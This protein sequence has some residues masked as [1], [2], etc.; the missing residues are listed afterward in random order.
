MTEEG[1][2]TLMEKQMEYVSDG[3]HN[4][5]RINYGEE[6]KNSYSYRMIMEN[7]IKGLLPC[8]VRMVNGDT[9]LYYEVQSKQT[10]HCRFE[11][12][13]IDYEALRNIFLHLCA[14]GNELEK[15]LL[16]LE[17]IVFSENYIFQ[18]VETGETYFM[19]LPNKEKKEDSYAEFME[20]IVKRIDHRD[21]KAVQISY[22]L[23]D[24]SRTEHISV[25]EIWELFE[26]ECTKKEIEKNIN[27]TPVVN[28]ETWENYGKK[29]E[30]EETVKNQMQKLE[31]NYME[32]ENSEEEK[33]AEKSK[34]KDIL[35]SCFCVITFTILLCI[36]ISVRLTY[37][38]ETLLLAGMAVD[39]GIFFIHMCY[40]YWNRRKKNKEKPNQNTSRKKEISDYGQ[41][42]FGNIWD[43]EAIAV[44]EDNFNLAEPENHRAKPNETGESESYTV[45]EKENDTYGET[46]FLEPE[47]ENILYGLGKYEKTMI[48]INKFPFTIGKL[49]E[50]A[51]YILRDNSISRLH[52]RFYQDNK[53]VYIMDLNSTNG[54]CRNGFRIPANQKILLEEGDELTFGK[55]RFYYR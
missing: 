55:I 19:F 4:Y 49:K 16:D 25:K 41:G 39:I 29:E 48:H 3:N 9:Y 13:E 27:N 34:W 31:G 17:N 10:L 5:L 40:K 33:G 35:I 22:R 54:T 47:S 11:I 44:K 43:I 21:I 8:R 53:E 23:Y 36:K 24:L 12:K 32:G 7:T 6:G 14:L 30:P 28:Y 20:Y 18:N 1:A 15:Y 42:E 45:Y 51:D 26:E 50:E 46:V 37:E 52:A 38:E 2:I